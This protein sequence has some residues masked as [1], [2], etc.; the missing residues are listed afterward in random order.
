MLESAP[1]GGWV[2]SIL[3]TGVAPGPSA[4]PGTWRGLPIFVQ[5][6]W[7][8]CSL[9]LASCEVCVCVCGYGLPSVCPGQR[10]HRE[11]RRGVGKR[12]QG[13]EQLGLHLQSELGVLLRR[14]EQAARAFGLLNLHYPSVVVCVSTWSLEGLSK[15]RP[16]R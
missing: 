9:S 16:I 14:W 4:A 13:Q 2:S 7:L 15:M 5:Y 12:A 6:L 11:K 3:L 10:S 8:S 1:H